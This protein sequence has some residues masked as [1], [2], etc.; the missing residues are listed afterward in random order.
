MLTTIQELEKEIDQFHKNIKASNELMKILTSIAS[1]TKEQTEAFEGRTKALHDELSELPP[2]LGN[3][4][5][6]KIESFAQEIHTEHQQ[7][8]SAVAKLIDGYRENLV[9]VESAIAKVPAELELQ[10]LK[11]RSQNVADLKQ[12][13]EQ[14]AAD[15][16][17][18]NE[19]FAKHLQ[20]VVGAIHAVPAQISEQTTQQNRAFLKELEKMMDA[21]LAQLSATEKRMEELS[22][23]L[24]AKYHAFASKLGSTDMDQV[25]QFCQAMNKSINTKLGLVLGGVAIA[26]IISVISLFI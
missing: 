24:E 7:Y 14:Y 17:K 22:Q 3:L 1:L 9:T 21:R 5:Q 18:V 19:A 16:T 26:V 23:Q 6:K 4:F 11:D 15:L 8:Q 12:I 25:Y 2:E 10:L 13:Q 20:T